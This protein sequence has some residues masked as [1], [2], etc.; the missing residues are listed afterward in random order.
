MHQFR[1]L[2]LSQNQYSEPLTVEVRY[3][4]AARVRL[5]LIT[6]GVVVLATVI[7]IIHGHLTHRKENGP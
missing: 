4:D 2:D 6:G 1:V 3:M 7:A 5:L